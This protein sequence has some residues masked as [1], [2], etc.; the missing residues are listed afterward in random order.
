MIS[1][2]NEIDRLVDLLNEEIRDPYG[3]DAAVRRISDR[4]RALAEL[5]RSRPEQGEVIDSSCVSD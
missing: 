3:K 2:P 5:L 1:V 4:L